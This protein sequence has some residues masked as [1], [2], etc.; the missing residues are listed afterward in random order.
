[1]RWHA[2]W[3]NPSAMSRLHRR[4][5]VENR[6]PAQPATVRPIIALLCFG[7]NPNQNGRSPCTLRITGAIYATDQRQRQRAWRERHRGEPRGNK[8][9]MMQLALLHARVARL[10]AGTG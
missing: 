9:M 2:S 1:M 4:Q 3:W 6:N 7:T 10:E 8:A 5:A